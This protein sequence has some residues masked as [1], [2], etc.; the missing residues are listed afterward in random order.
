MCLDGFDEE[1]AGQVKYFAAHS[2]AHARLL[3]TASKLL[4]SDTDT[5]ALVENAWRERAFHA[6]YER[7]LLLCAAMRFD[8]L[9]DP[10]HPLF[11]AIATEPP[12]EASISE[13][14]VRAALMR[15]VALEAMMR[16][17]VQT[18]E[19]MR[20]VAWRWPL[21][22]AGFTRPIALVD[23]GCSAGLNLVADRIDLSWTDDG[24]TALPSHSSGIA[25]RIGFDRSPV[26]VRDS[27]QADWL[28]ACVWPGQ[29]PRLHR[30]EAAIERAREARSSGELAIVQADMLEVPSHLD[31]LVREGKAAFVYAYQTIV[32]DYLEPDVRDRYQAAMHEWLRCHPRRSL[33]AEFERA[34]S[35]APQPAEL[36]VSFAGADAIRTLVLG[37]A[38]Y[39]PHKVH[40]HAAALAEVR[41]AFAEA[42]G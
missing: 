33:W 17:Y 35:G 1:A 10:A 5:R 20:A 24:G 9:R 27:D 37:W 3:E 30:L 31:A 19:V 21:A 14:A 22:A 2:P 25:L 38:D 41:G 6:R 18:N 12:D 40:V 29:A 42:R 4:G 16:R 32:R 23:A 39:H 7:P 13:D 11:R 15:P 34:P 26:D 36:R 8:A 28:R